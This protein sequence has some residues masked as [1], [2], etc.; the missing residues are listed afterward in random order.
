M[1]AIKRTGEEWRELV[2]QQRASGLTMKTWCAANGV[3]QY[4]MADRAS[5]L[6][7]EGLLTEPKPRR[8]GRPQ[9][10]SEW[11]EVTSL[12]AEP[13]AH[14]PDRA[15]STEIEVRIGG[16]AVIVPEK[17]SETAFVQ[18]CKALMSLC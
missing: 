3:N 4:T 18:V 8:G 13:T 12:P 5:K 6:R 14:Q 11:L 7:K 16:F 1:T 15:Q 17:F 10:K 2:Q 9:P